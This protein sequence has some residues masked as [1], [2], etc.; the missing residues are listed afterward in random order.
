[1]IRRRRRRR[2]AERCGVSTPVSPHW[3]SVAAS[4]AAACRPEA[5]SDMTDGSR[6]S[7]Q[8]RRVSAAGRRAP[9]QPPSRAHLTDDRHRCTQA[10]RHTGR[11]QT[12]LKHTAVIRHSPKHSRH[13]TQLK[14][15]AVIRR[16]PKHSRHQTQPE[17]QPSS[18]TARNTAVIRHS[19]KHS[20]HQT[21]SETQPSSDTVR[22]TAVIRHSPKHSRHQT[23]SETQPSSDAARNTADIRRS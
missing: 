8:R 12:Q 21:Q 1:M 23:Q 4:S 16:S 11:H 20:R 19:P 15:T 7:R 3:S 9:T 5:R 14:N 18:D 22:N 13:Q 6:S 2:G 10:D 17:T